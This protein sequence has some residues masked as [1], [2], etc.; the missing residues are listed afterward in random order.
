M[1][2]M[3]TKCEIFV[4][5]GLC[6]LIGDVAKRAHKEDSDSEYMTVS[7]VTRVS[8]KANICEVRDTDTRP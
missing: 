8:S 4:E 5:C 3:L 1:C 6:L 7:E 2:R